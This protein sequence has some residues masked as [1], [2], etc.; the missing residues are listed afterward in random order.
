MLGRRL[1]APGSATQIEESQR[2]Y[3]RTYKGD[4]LAMLSTCHESYR[5]TGPHLTIMTRENVG[6]DV[7]PLVPLCGLHCAA[8]YCIVGFLD[9][10]SL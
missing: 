8:G 7:K 10:Q 4:P 3:Q 9:V 5:C 2:G 1:R 6:A